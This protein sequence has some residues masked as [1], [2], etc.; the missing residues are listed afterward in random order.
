MLYILMLSISALNHDRQS[1]AF[2]FSYMNQE[3]A[4]QLERTVLQ[5]ED[6]QYEAFE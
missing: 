1:L 4:G 5:S 6:L 2:V 3:N